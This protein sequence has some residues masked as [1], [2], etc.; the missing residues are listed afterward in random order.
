MSQSILDATA[1][2]TSL[3]SE[4]VR[5][6]AKSVHLCD[7]S[8]VVLPHVGERLTQPQRRP[9][10][11][12]MRQQHHHDLPHGP[13]SC[14]VSEKKSRAHQARYSLTAS[15]IPVEAG[16]QCGDSPVRSCVIS[17][18]PKR[19]IRE[20]P[21]IHHRYELRVDLKARS[22]LR[23]N[24]IPILIPVVMPGQFLCIKLTKSAIPPNWVSREL[25]EPGWKNL[26]TGSKG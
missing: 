20:A 9:H 3:I 7:G 2:E 13:F 12:S 16:T 23:E 6:L 18:T 11:S 25:T 10:L 26:A 17:L 19:H 21:Y 24:D 14:C 5:N 4:L 8:A 1:G 22:G 15:S